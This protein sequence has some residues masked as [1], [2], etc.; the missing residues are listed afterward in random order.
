LSPFGAE[1]YDHWLDL[2]LFIER[3][4]ATC[5]EMLSSLGL[6]LAAIGLF[7]AV[8]YSVNERRKELGIRVALGARPMQ[9]LGMI[10]RHTILI[11]GAGVAIGMALG[12]TVTMLLRSQFYGISAVEFA[13]L[14]PV[15]AAMLAISVLVAYVSARPWLSIDP[16]EAVRYG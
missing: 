9:L 11:A 6:L 1:T 8:S 13:V 7:G 3:L 10:L 16:M 5:A 4:I 15:G 2:T 12:V 14:I